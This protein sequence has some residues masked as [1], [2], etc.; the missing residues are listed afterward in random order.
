MK[1]RLLSLFISVLALCLSTY[2]VQA[3]P[4]VDML[5]VGLCYSNEA[6]DRCSISSDSG[7]FVGTET[8]RKFNQTDEID[9]N[10]IEITIDANG[11]C[12]FS[13]KTFDTKSGNLTFMPKNDEF[14]GFKGNKYRGGIQISNAGNGKM[15]IVNF[16]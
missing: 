1:K 4:N 8:N 5:R 12:T 14:I 13:D 15:N 2:T 3:K 16:I 6:V 10:N 11:I 7:F 9:S